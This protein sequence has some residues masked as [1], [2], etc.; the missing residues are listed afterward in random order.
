MN[1]ESFT[2]QLQATLARRTGCH[3]HRQEVLKNNGVW[4]T[5]LTIQRKRTSLLPCIYVEPLYELF[6]QGE[7]WEEIVNRALEFEETE[8][9]REGFPTEDFLTYEKVK[10]NIYYRIINQE[11]NE[12]L[13][14]DIPHRKV[15]DLA[16]VY[17][18]EVETPK[19]GQ[20]AILIH[21]LHMKEWKITI[22]EVDRIATE[23]TEQNKKPIV[24]SI[25]EVVRTHFCSELDEFWE[26]EL[27]DCPMYVVSNEDWFYGASVLLYEGFLK[28]ISDMK[29]E[30][31]VI[32]PSSI[33][34][35][36]F[37]KEK[38]AWEQFGI[39]LKEI[40]ETVNRDAVSEEEYLSH[41]VYVYDRQ[42]ETLALYDGL[43][44]ENR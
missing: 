24:R 29:K 25:G 7:L 4:Y 1:K 33:H 11:A 35:F 21:F 19:L 38:T 14:E 31:L 43:R 41:Y 17:Y 8:T 10:K 34:E 40:V 16:K 13:L 22:E 32:F 2:E 18:V 20:G 3:V 5:S 15:L 30:N 28:T 44:T 36:I 42:K 12:K 9:V 27:L 37:M 6:R 26:D 39:D 23:N